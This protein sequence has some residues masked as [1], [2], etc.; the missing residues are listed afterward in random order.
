MQ[1]LQDILFKT[2]INSSSLPETD[3]GGRQM[4]KCPITR[5]RFLEPHQNLPETVEPRMRR[6]HHPSPRLVS[7][8]LF[9]VVPLLSPGNDVQNI[10]AGD[11]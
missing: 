9:L 6:F 2:Y 8:D 3:D 5:R 1:W 7:R 10:H 11:H 4:K